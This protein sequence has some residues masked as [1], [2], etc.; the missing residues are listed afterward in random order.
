MSHPRVL[1]QLDTDSQA[2]SFDSIVA[3]DSGVEHLLQ[4]SRM[5]ADRVEGLVHGAMFTRGVDDLKNTAIFVGGSDVDAVDLIA[6]RVTE[7]FF[8]PLRVSL[9]VD[10]NGANTTAAAA[11]LCAERHV[12]CGGKKVAILGGTGPVGQRIAQILANH[13]D[14]HPETRIRIV[15]RSLDKAATICDKLSRETGKSF[16][17]AVGGSNANENLNAVADAEVVFAAGA[18]GVPLLVGNWWAEAKSVKV[19]IDLNAV[20]PAGIEGIAVSDRGAKRGSAVF[21][22]AIGVGGLKM[23]IHKRCLQS[24]FESSKQT[25][26]VNEIYA[27]GKGCAEGS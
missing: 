6:T 24:L 14:P 12:D 19:A 7:C 17:E 1:I 18:A 25:L 16:F 4:Y 23:K 5:T 3:I 26:F 15:S 8:G 27:I 2:S 21:Y 11:V 20:P 10:P 13:T 22:G 9:I